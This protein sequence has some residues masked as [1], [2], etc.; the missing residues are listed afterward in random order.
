MELEQ[1]EQ[2]RM[3][4]STGRIGDPPGLSNCSGSGQESQVS[5]CTVDLSSTCS[6]I[7]PMVTGAVG[8]SDWEAGL[9]DHHDQ[10]CVAPAVAAGPEASTAPAT[11]VSPQQPL[12]P[13]DEWEKDWESTLLRHLDQVT[14]AATATTPTIGVEQQQQEGGP[15]TTAAAVQQHHLIGGLT[16]QPNGLREDDLLDSR[17]LTSETQRKKEDLDNLDL[18]MEHQSL[19][20]Q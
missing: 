13:G 1:A 19:W 18:P 15:T 4:Q 8:S 2:H 16:E 11:A 12:P 20:D 14:A 6:N 17:S 9:L 5:S 10:H 3:E 7:I